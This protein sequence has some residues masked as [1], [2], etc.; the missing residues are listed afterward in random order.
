M[1]MCLSVKNV[2]CNRQLFQLQEKLL[3]R[4]KTELIQLAENIHSITRLGIL[5]PKSPLLSSKNNFAL[6]ISRSMFLFGDKAILSSFILHVLFISTFTH[7]PF[8]QR[9]SAKFQCLS[10]KED[11]KQLFPLIFERT[12]L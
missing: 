4:E 8:P 7:L 11:E 12:N 5:Y 6:P 2:V 9:W 1:Y 10:T 3:K